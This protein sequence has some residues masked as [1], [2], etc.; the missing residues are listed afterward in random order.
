MAQDQLPVSADV[1]AERR[2]PNCGTRVARDANT[3]FMCGHD[4]RIQPKRQRRVS[5]VD[6]LLVVAVLGVLLVWW[7]LG[8]QPQNEAEEPVAVDMIL[9]TNVP[10]LEPTATPTLEPTATPAPTPISVAPSFTTHTVESGETL[11]GIAG[12]YGV[13]VEDIQQANNLTDEL[14]RPGDELVIPVQGEAAALTTNQGP[15]TNFSY[16]VA[17][18]DTVISIATRF[19]STVQDILNANGLSAD[20][21]IRPGD[22]LI[23]PV[24]DVPDEVTS[25]APPV[26]PEA[27]TSPA[28][29]P[30]S[31][32]YIEPRLVGPP[33][34]TT[35]S[36]NEAA[37]LR[38]VSVDVLAPNEWY[39]LMV[40]PTD[41]AAQVVPSIWTKATSHRLGAEYAPPEGESATY[42]WQVSV[43]RVIDDGSGTRQ[44]EA[45]SPPSALRSFTWE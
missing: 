29:G 37:L 28:T 42:S 17:T 4:L 22:E 13:T 12:V 24:R 45:A 10:V 2:C 41:G 7:R 39:V 40:Y 27:Q 21:V 35:L 1:G 32:I 16:T 44:L 31:A 20:D 38:W 11:L 14:I 5:W 43:V 33:N 25:A 9:P 19:G 3:C 8:V 34:R 6:A 18:G 23:V 26:A 36:R 30:D 15:T